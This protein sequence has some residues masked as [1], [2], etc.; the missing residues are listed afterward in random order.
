[1]SETP[2]STTGQSVREIPFLLESAGMAGTME[3]ETWENILDEM[4][5]EDLGVMDSQGNGAGHIL[6]ERVNN[7]NLLR[8]ALQAGID[9]KTPRHIDQASPIHLAANRSDPLAEQIVRWLCEQVREDANRRGPGGMCPLEIAGHGWRH[10][11]LIS[12][13]VMNGAVVNSRH[14]SRQWTPLHIAARLTKNHEILIRLLRHG[15]DPDLVDVAGLKPLDVLVANP[16]LSSGD[17]GVVQLVENTYRPKG[18]WAG[19]IMK[20]RRYGLPMDLKRRRKQ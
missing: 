15:A 8:A 17:R 19:R 10:P 20:P 4:T 9:F 16:N 6:V 13:L 1:M 11:G 12:S 7:L 18:Q 3:L 5:P 2:A 14:A